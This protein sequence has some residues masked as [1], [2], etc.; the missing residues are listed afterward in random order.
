M[1]HIRGFIAIWENDRYCKYPV[2]IVKWYTK[3]KIIVF[4]RI[5]G[6][7]RRIATLKQAQSQAEKI[8]HP[9]QEKANTV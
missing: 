6:I 2:H 4:G 5:F 8:E 1:R 9:H 7:L 3:C